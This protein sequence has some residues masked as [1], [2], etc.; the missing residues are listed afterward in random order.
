MPQEQPCWSCGEPI[1]F[2]RT[3][4]GKLMSVNA[5]TVT[6]GDTEFEPRS[7]HEPHWATCPE[8]DLWRHDAK[9]DDSWIPLSLAPG[10]RAT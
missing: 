4:S 9:G 1:I 3:G 5:D 7:G 6:P 2:L 8:R 10:P